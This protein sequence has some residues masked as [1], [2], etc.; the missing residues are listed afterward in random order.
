MSNHGNSL[1]C[2]LMRTSR[3]N[4]VTPTRAIRELIRTDKNETIRNGQHGWI[5]HKD[6]KIYLINPD[7]S[8]IDNLEKNSKLVVFR[9]QNDTDQTFAIEVRNMP[10][11]MEVKAGNLDVVTST[12]KQHPYALT[13]TAINHVPSMVPDLDKMQKIANQARDNDSKT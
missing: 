12:S 1:S 11:M 7:L 2:L 9:T 6:Q 5:K 10:K 3:S 4:W 13:H 8:P